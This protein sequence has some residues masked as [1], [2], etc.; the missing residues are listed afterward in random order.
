M[1]FFFF[2]A[3]TVQFLVLVLDSSDPEFG[4]T[5][6]A[7]PATVMILVFAVYGLREENKPV[8]AGFIT[9]CVLGLAYFI[10]KLARMYDPSRADKYVHT[11][12]FLTFFAV[13]SLLVVGGTVVNAIFCFRN[14]GKG[15]KPHISMKTESNKTSTVSDGNERK[16]TLAE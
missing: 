8:M 5:I 14:F 11:R 1:D 12:R 15:L 6:F 10:F 3:F 7:I 4:L 13:L 2:V 16:M 9:G